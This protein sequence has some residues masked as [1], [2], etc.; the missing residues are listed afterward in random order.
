MLNWS[1]FWDF[2]NVENIEFYAFFNMMQLDL[3]FLLIGF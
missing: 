1:W 2:L 3:E